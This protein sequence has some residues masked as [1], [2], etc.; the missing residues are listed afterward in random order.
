MTVRLPPKWV[1]GI[2]RNARSVCPKYT[3]ECERVVRETVDR[4]GGLDL[5]FNNVG[6]QSQAQDSYRNVEDTPQDMCD[7][8]LDV[9]LK[10]YFLMSKYAR[11]RS[12]AV[13]RRNL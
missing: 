2:S 6:I 9:N 1:F 12:D 13:V 3:S 10:S 11:P 5:L 8:I 7:R 4:F